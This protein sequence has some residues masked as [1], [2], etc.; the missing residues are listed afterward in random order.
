[1]GSSFSKEDYFLRAIGRITVSFASL[2]NV[3]AESIREFITN[4]YELYECITSGMSFNELLKLI[5]TLFNYRI[6]DE[7]AIKQFNKLMGELDRLRVDRNDIIHSEWFLP[8]SGSENAIRK[9]RTK[10]VKKGLAVNTYEYKLTELHDFNMRIWK[11]IWELHSIMEN[12]RPT[13]LKHRKKTSNRTAT[14]I[15]LETLRSWE[16][17]SK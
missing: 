5:G 9:K 17:G 11:A 3:I 2:E 1:M 4:D 7:D 13:I 14:K 10:T 8:S 15:L 6:S 16:K 12:N